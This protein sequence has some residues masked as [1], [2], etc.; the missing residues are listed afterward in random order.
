MSSEPLFVV[1][2]LDA[3]CDDLDC[4]CESCRVTGAL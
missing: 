1:V 4:G 3:I 2:D